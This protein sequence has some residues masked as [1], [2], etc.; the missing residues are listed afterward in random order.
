LRALYDRRISTPPI[1]ERDAYFPNADFFLD[2]YPAVR[3]E[4]LH[5]VSRL[6]QIPRF[7]DAG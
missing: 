3:R 7:H 4:S 5:V 6:A 2:A 1:L